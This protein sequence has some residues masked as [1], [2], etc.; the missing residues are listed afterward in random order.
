MPGG[1]VE[2]LFPVLLL[3]LARVL[4]KLAFVRD[5]VALTGQRLADIR[6]VVALVRGCVTTILVQIVLTPATSATLRA[7]GGATL[8]LGVQLLKLGGL[9]ILLQR[10]AVQLGGLPMEIT[11]R[12]VG[13]F[14]HEALAAFGSLALPVRTLARPIA[15]LLGT[16]SPLAMLRGARC[17]HDWTVLRLTARTLL[18]AGHA[19]AVG[20]ASAPRQRHQPVR[21]VMRRPVGVAL[22]FATPRAP[23]P[24]TS[25]ALP[26]RPEHVRADATPSNPH[27]RPEMVATPTRPPAVKP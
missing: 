17:I 3:S 25:P 15:E 11:E 27:I 19:P 10:L 4:L 1:R 8:V 23:T 26:S 12:W 14:G 16:P 13:R 7:L 24:S 20:V 5:N 2:A 21:A 22:R 18:L 6:D 9:L